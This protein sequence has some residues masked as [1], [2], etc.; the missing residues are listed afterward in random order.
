[1]KRGVVIVNTARGALIDEPALV[2]ALRSGQVRAAGLDVFATEPAP[3]DTPLFSLPNVALAPHMAWITPETL[4]RSFAVIADNCQ[5]LRNGEPL[6]HAI[7][8]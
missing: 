4:E 2:A 6:R 8:L 1:M 5:R 3:A 7:A